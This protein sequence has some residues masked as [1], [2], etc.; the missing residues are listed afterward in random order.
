V[1]DDEEDLCAFTPPTIEPPDEPVTD[2]STEDTNL[3]LC[4]VCKQAAGYGTLR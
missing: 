1:C 4:A 2:I 3:D